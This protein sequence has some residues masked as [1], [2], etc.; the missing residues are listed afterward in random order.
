MIVVNYDRVLA[1]DTWDTQFLPP[2]HFVNACLKSLTSDKRNIV[3][4]YSGRNKETLT[5]WFGA[6]PRLILGAEYGAFVKLNKSQEWVSLV[7]DNILQFSWQ[8]AVLPIVKDFGDRTPGSDIEAKEHSITW[9]YGDA[10]PAYG[11][12]Q[13]KDMLSH[14]EEVL[15]NY[16]VQ[17]VKR[18]KAL[19]VRSISCGQKH[20]LRYIFENILDVQYNANAKTHSAKGIKEGYVLQER[21]F[22]FVFVR[23]R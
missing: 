6:L 4:L 2:V 12:W 14:L 17:L 13:A 8:G 18:E 19:E 1:S 20:L 16:P 7:H 10:D 5:S 9:F 21:P 11:E 22:D 3:V 15:G 23:C